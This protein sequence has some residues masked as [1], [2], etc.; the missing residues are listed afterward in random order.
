MN[1]DQ[2]EIENISC[3]WGQKYKVMSKLFKD[4]FFFNSHLRMFIDF[5]ERKGK[6]MCVRGEGGETHKLVASHS[7]PN[8]VL[9]LQSRYVPCL[10]IGPT[11][12]QCMR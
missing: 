1:K 8:R 4:F 5:K 12:F 3:C 9:N 7:C 11:T 2:G 10:G 6:S